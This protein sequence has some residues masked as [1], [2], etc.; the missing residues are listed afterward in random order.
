MTKVFHEVVS[1][2]YADLDFNLPDLIEF[3]L[4]LGPFENTTFSVFSDRPR[5]DILKLTLASAWVSEGK[6]DRDASHL[7]KSEDRDNNITPD[8]FE[9]QWIACFKSD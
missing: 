4:P 2:V 6:G 1:F 7:L 5:H 9:L 3:Y 8:N